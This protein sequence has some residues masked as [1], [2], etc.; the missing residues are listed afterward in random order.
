MSDIVKILYNGVDAFA[1]QPT[2]FVSVDEQSIYAGEYWG[3]AE[4]VTLVG[5]I[6]GCTFSG[7]VDAQNQILNKFNKSYQTLQIWQEEGGVSGMVFQ[8]DL[9]EIQSISFAQDR[10]LGVQPYTINLTCYPSGLFS[11]TYGILNPQDSWNFSEREDAS[12][13]V[14]HT[15][16][17]QPFN[18][19]NGQSN[20][21][22]NAR[23]WAFGR[24]GINSTVYPILISGVSP[25]NF[26]LLTQQESIDRFNGTYSIVENYT[27]DLAR[28]GYGVIRYST[29]LESGS[30][31]II[32]N[33][34]G[35]AQGCS[36]NITGLRYAFNRLDKTA[37]A[38]KAYQSAFN[39]TDLNPIPLV[40]SFNEDPYS[41]RID[42]SY[43]YDN[44]NLPEVWFDYTVD[45]SVGTNGL[46][47][48]GINGTIY[49]RGGD[50]LSK[51]SRALAYA[52]GISL[53]NLTLPFYNSFDTSSSTPLHPVP[54]TTSQ[55]NNQSDGTVQLSATFNNR[56]QLSSVLDRIDYTID[57]TPCLA[58]VDAK[59]VLDGNGTWSVVTLNYAKRA[60]L[61]L[62]GTAIVNR[63]QTSAA[64]VTALKQIALDIFTQY[65]RYSSAALEQD[66]I[67]V[68]RTDDKVLSFSFVWS[69]GPTIT[70][71]PTSVSTLA[72]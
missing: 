14:T 47:S 7:I 21:L 25:D 24:T 17:C 42:F 31:G 28:T 51:L 19:S 37:I 2:P 70:V 6:T 1:P 52:S 67:T 62:N 36:R 46:I 39:R 45:C 58:Q 30:N 3:R 11:G 41:T 63:Q 20:A 8:K 27:N 13:D 60:I 22:D 66:I 4:N 54:I 33:L 65:G 26:C 44:K 71:G 29:S 69:F 38:N 57:I 5:Q 61:V 55:S 15:I 59:P 68:N 64:G 35:T 40:Q 12:L 53:Y 49:A 56:N 50:T 16:S 18:T 72:V 9:V 32:V 23:N 48:A 34:N 10:M 43:T